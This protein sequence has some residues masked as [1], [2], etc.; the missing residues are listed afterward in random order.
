MQPQSGRGANGRVA[1]TDSTHQ[2]SADRRARIRV[3]SV[4]AN[5]V[6]IRHLT[7]PT[8]DD[9][10]VRLPD[11]PTDEPGKWWPPVMLHADWVRA[12]QAEFDLMHVHFG[13]DAS[14]PSALVALGDALAEARRP[15]VM[16]VHDLRNPHHADRET[17]D[18]HLEALLP[19]ASKVFTLTSGAA[20][21]IRER[22]G[23]TAE[24]T[25]HPHVFSFDDVAA[26]RPESEH[27]TIG[28][29]CK[30]LRAS[31]SPLPIIKSIAA[32]LPEYPG[33]VL[34]VDAH[35]DIM[36]P[37]FRRYDHELAVVL[38][39]LAASGRIDLRVHDY[40]TD[41]E[42]RDY[43]R[44]IDVSVLPYRF[45]THS[46][47]AEGCYDLGTGVIAPNRG[48]YL[49]QVPSIEYRWHDNDELDVESLRRAV[50]EAWQMRGQAPRASV[51]ERVAQRECVAAQHERAYEDVLDA[52]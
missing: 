8:G 51:A 16:T 48:Y 33:G 21:E 5:H 36:T 32:M 1:S 15:L 47:W 26:P 27:F 9:R 30:S 22:Y 35:T 18:R 11:P 14:D 6:Y 52:S 25:P 34:R 12:H 49:E 28:V 40:F 46:G 24:V 10:V 13:F 17:H 45:G 31:M 43:F 4:P 39:D 19:A 44:S 42:L 41:D 23:V 29:H 2:C 20:A 37:G 7:S 50:D 3:A 38:R